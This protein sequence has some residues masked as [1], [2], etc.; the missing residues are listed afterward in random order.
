[1]SNESFIGEYSIPESICTKL[2]D[3]FNSDSA[4]KSSGQVGGGRIDT[5]IKSS[6]DVV[7][8][9]DEW[10]TI[11]I[12]NE[13]IN[14]LEK[15]TGKYIKEYPYSLQPGYRFQI[16]Q[17]IRIQ[18]YKPNEGF[19]E[20]HCERYNLSHRH[21]VWTTYLNTVK[22]K[23]ETEFYY[24]GIKIKANKGKAV[25]FPAE[26]T[27]THRGVPSPTE[28]KYIITGWYEFITSTQTF[29]KRGKLKVWKK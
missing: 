24:Q 17:P 21:L 5:S 6:T 9:K 29:F 27:H 23:G 16:S 25:I 20:Y 4:I 26:W 19:Y 1:M 8:M 22:D 15:C 10:K 14:E 2:I 11:P 7:L 13:Y 3:F 18:Y 28:E 12:I